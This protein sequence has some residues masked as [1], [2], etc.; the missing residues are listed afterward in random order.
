VASVG[1]SVWASVWD[2]VLRREL[3]EC[4]SWGQHDAGGFAFYDF[5]REI[6]GLKSQT[7]KLVPLT[8]LAQETGW[9]LFYADFAILS[10]KPIALHRNQNGKLH[11]ETGPA[12]EWADEYKLFRLNGVSVTEQVA[13]LKSEDVTIDLIKKYENEPSVR[14]EI[15]KKVSFE[16]WINRGFVVADGI[17]EKLVSQ[18]TLGDVSV[19]ETKNGFVVKRGNIFSHGDTV[20][21]AIADLRYKIS[22]RDKS[23]YESWKLED[24]KPVEEI[25]QA[26]RVI[27]GACESGTRMFCESQSLPEAMKLKVAVRMTK[28]RFGHEEFAGFFK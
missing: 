12:I 11:N 20:E 25:I 5:F 27:T 2:S 1:D 14:S 21:K 24:E 13:L 3:D 22:D 23:I 18:K 26:Y 10:E 19:F 15:I 16:E 17:I 8:V 28:G 6:C 4:R 7:E 9:H